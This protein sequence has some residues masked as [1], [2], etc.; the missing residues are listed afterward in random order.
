MTVVTTRPD[1]LLGSSGSPPV[2]GAATIVD[3]LSD[4][5][6]SSY[7]TTAAGSSSWEVGFDEPVL[8][9]GSL[10]TRVSARLRCAVT[11]ASKEYAT[12]VSGMDVRPTVNWT[13]PTTITLTPAGASSMAMPA[14]SLDAWLSGVYALLV[15]GSGTGAIV[16]LKSYEAFF[17]VALVE[18]PEVAVSA[19][20]GTITT[21]NKPLT[22]WANTL[23]SDGGAQSRYEVKVYS[24]AQY[25][26][27]GFDPDTS[28]PTVSSGQLS[29]AATSWQMTATLP[30]DT[31]RAY[32]RSGQTVNG[33]AHW[34]D[35]D[36]EGF[37]I[38]V[39]VPDAPALT[40]TGL[41]AHGCVQLDMSEQGSGPS[42][43]AFELQRS[44][45]GGLTWEPV[46][47]PEYV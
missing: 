2:T 13:T 38:D 17:D 21:T 29:G 41:D 14:A 42:T 27:G 4:D 20:T 30:D 32:V 24:A 6:D 31:Y 15:P 23:D 10:V 11:T 16:Q 44:L 25:G 34:S 7:V 46:R 26:A 5:S 33:T 22:S 18:Q 45:D 40:V 19:P 43:D 47:L 37:V 9:T 8:P 36:Y 35:W 12:Q 28:T 3:A 1:S 39:A